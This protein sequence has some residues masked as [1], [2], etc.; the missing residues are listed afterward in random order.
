[1]RSFDPAISF[2]MRQKRELPGIVRRQ[3]RERAG[4]VTSTALSLLQLSSDFT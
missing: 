2:C 1:M 4:V 3:K